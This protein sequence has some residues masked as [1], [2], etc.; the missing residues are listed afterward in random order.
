MG[1]SGIKVIGILI[2]GKSVADAILIGSSLIKIMK[3][4]QIS[5]HW[6]NMLYYYLIMYISSTL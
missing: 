3:Q 2:L 4:L 6:K 1:I 5:N